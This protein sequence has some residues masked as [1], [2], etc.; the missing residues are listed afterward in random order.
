MAFLIWSV[1]GARSAKRQRDDTTA[2]TLELVEPRGVMR[3][4]KL[5]GH[6]YATIGGGH[7]A[8]AYNPRTPEDAQASGTGTG[9][10]HTEAA[11]FDPDSL[12]AAIK[13]LEHHV[14]LFLPDWPGLR[15]VTFA[16]DREFLGRWLAQTPEEIASSGSALVSEFDGWLRRASAEVSAKLGQYGEGNPRGVF[17]VSVDRE[18]GLSIELPP[19]RIDISAK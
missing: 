12:V 13:K 10:L 19:P 18:D 9:K 7:A 15:G 5:W 16:A 11:F 2:R 1:R 17:T 3:E 4:V 6:V 14:R 8:F